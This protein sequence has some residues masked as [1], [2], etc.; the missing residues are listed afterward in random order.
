MDTLKQLTQLI[1]EKFDIELSTLQP[2][3]P[4]SE[5]GLDSL[6]LAE[7]LFTLEEDFDIQF[8]DRPENIDTLTGLAALIDALRVPR[9][10]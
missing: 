6:S 2:D 7:L 8:P 3:L 10:A 1:H 4:L 9:P 5:Y